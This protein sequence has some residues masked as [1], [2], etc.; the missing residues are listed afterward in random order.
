MDY[1]KASKNNVLKEGQKDKV[2]KLYNKNRKVFK[3]IY[4]KLSKYEEFKPADPLI[5]RKH[6][7][8][9]PI[10]FPSLTP[11]LALP[12]FNYKSNNKV[13][14]FK[15]IP[16]NTKNIY[17]FNKDIQIYNYINMSKMTQRLI[18][19]KKPPDKNGL[20]TIDNIINLNEIENKRNERKK[21]SIKVD[22]NETKLNISDNINNLIM[23]E[24]I[25][26]FESNFECGNL[27]LAY[28][29]NSSKE[30]NEEKMN[31]NFNGIIHNNEID[32]YQLFMHN[33]TNTI[34]YSQ[35]FFFRIKNGKKIKK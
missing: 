14:S 4:S 6:I 21:K 32:N 28:L 16:N 2:I 7:K 30:N 13:E 24:D 35:W 15:L 23:S 25:I 3:N 33:D 5:N 11:T 27:Q 9:N 22:K 1:I 17:L 19:C 29:I 34:G 31:S 12:Y 18:Y 20:F 8:L 26:N 10:K